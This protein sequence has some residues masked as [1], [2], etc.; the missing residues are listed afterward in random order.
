[1]CKQKVLLF[2]F[3]AIINIA[4]LVA[5]LINKSIINK[6][7]DIIREEKKNA[8]LKIIE[9]DLRDEVEPNSWYT[10]VIGIAVCLD[11]WLIGAILT[12]LWASHFFIEVEK[13]DNNK[14]L[15]GDSFGAV[16]ALIS[17]FA[18]GAMIVTFYFQR[19]ELKL[20][21]KELE[22][23]RMEFE[24]QNQTLGLQRFEN[25]FFN[26]LQL[27]QEIVAGLE[28]VLDSREIAEDFDVKKIKTTYK[29]REVFMI[30]YEENSY[31]NYGIKAIIEQRGISSYSSFPFISLF[32]HYFRHLYAIINF[33]DKSPE[34]EKFIE[35][36]VYDCDSQNKLF[37]KRY[38]YTKILRATLSH[39]ELVLLY[40]NGLSEFGKEKLKP[41]IEKYSIL[42]NL[43]EGLLAL[44][45][46]NIPF[47]NSDARVNFITNCKT[48]GYPPT[49]YLFNITETGIFE[50][51]Y[52]VSA[53]YHNK[54]D[55]KKEI[56]KVL[57]FYS[58]LNEL[59]NNKPDITAQ[60]DS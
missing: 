33:I 5:Y 1:M 25:T 16:N 32:D 42:N 4:W 8:G 21:R 2:V 26:M 20:Q 53:F 17:A 50:R 39:Y 45:N 56:E 44:S 13:D 52:N 10:W 6:K 51:R 12:H 3:L 43:N 46:D 41:L 24:Q 7:I 11:V 28:Y 18:F 31:N 54:E 19:Y 9:K 36:N 49:D 59:K 15:F 22:A 14:A 57:N 29:G 58:E 40:Y 35:R 23:Q 27:Q 38:E 47:A 55:Q 60:F 34:I 37:E 48:K 30:M